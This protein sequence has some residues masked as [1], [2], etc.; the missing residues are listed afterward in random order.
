MKL[1]KIF[2]F[3]LF[4]F[5]AAGILSVNRAVI[6]VAV[7]NRYLWR[8]AAR[9]STPQVLF[10]ARKLIGIIGKQRVYAERGQKI[11]HLFTDI[12]KAAFELGGNG[13]WRH[14]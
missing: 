14:R 3:T 4:A 5:A 8:V 11:I 7:S 10:D 13:V 2:V 9:R 1:L 12:G 6:G